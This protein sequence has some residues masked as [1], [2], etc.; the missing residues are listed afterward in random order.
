MLLDVVVSEAQSLAF[1]VVHYLSNSSLP[2]VGGSCI[3]QMNKLH[4]HRPVASSVINPVF[5]SWTGVPLL[6]LL[7][8]FMEEVLGIADLSVPSENDRDIACVSHRLRN[9]WGKCV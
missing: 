6:C 2:G 5:G 1:T 7:L 4:G 9:D 3:R 8:E